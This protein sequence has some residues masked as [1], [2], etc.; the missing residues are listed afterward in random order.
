M[1][2]VYRLV[3][4]SALTATEFDGNHHDHDDRLTALENAS[5]PDIFADPAFEVVGDQFYVNLAGETDPEGPFDLP[6]A[7]QWNP[8]GAW[9]PS[10]F[11]ALYDTVYYGSTLYLVAFSHTSDTT[12]DPGAND[13]MGHDY[14]EVIFT[15]T[16]A[17]ATVIDT[18]EEE[19]ST[20]LDHAGCYIRCASET[21]TVVTILSDAT[22]NHN[23]DTEIE[24]RLGVSGVSMTFV[25]ET[26]GSTDDDAV[27]IINYPD[28]DFF[29]SAS[30]KGAVIAIKKVAADEWDCFGLLD[31][32]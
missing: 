16:A 4:G 14:Y 25:S 7:G 20:I 3:K 26:P 10:T 21:G 29:L 5:T 1:P 30:K 15:F 32:M 18:T 24:Y 13:G 8:R 19:L 28:E 9:A 2:I 17:P 6:V 11:Y 27:P 12:F 23:I 22:A 31:P